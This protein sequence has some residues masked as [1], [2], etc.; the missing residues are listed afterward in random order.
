[1]RITAELIPGHITKDLELPEG[2][3]GYDL[4]K[5]LNLA[6]DVH[7]LARDDVPIPID[8]TLRDGDRLRVIAVVSGG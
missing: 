5:T 3:S 8:E 2:A 6:P 4:I 7:I 1:M